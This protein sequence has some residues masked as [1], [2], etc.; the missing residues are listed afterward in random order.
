MLTAPAQQRTTKPPTAQRK[1]RKVLSAA[2]A[3]ELVV[4][5]RRTFADH[6]LKTYGE[7]WL[8]PMLV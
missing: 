4:N 2:A 5:T 3:T 7:H 6:G 1:D 8:R